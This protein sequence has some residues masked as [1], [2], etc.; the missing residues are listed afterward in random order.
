MALGNFAFCEQHG[1]ATSAN[2]FLFWSAKSKARPQFFF[3]PRQFVPVVVL[4]DME[5]DARDVP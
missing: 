4:A 3:V 2:V 5:I 1:R